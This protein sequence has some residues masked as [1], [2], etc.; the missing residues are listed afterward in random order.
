[1]PF[2]HFSGMALRILMFL[3]TTSSQETH[4]C[5]GLIL[6]TTSMLLSNLILSAVGLYSESFEAGVQR[7]EY[8]TLDCAPKPIM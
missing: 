5:T 7:L 4:C 6:I 8:G 3:K 2:S 1:M